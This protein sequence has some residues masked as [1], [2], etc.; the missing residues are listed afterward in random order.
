MWAYI[1][2]FLMRRYRF[3]HIERSLIKTLI[4]ILAIDAFRTLFESIFFGA[5]STSLSGFLPIGVHDFLIR[6]EI[7]F[8]PKFLNVI[9]AALIIGILL[10]KWFPAEKRDRE[11]LESTIKEH[12]NKLEKRN[13]QLR[14]EITERKK[15][16]DTL[17]KSEEQYRLLFDLLPFGGEVIDSKGKIIKCSPSTSQML[18]YKTSEIIGKHITELLT[19]DSVHIFKKKFPVLLS[20]ESVTADIKMIRKDG[21]KLNIMRAAQPILNSDGKVES[22]LALNIDITERKK[23]EEQIAK[24]LEIK[25]AL[26][27]EVYHR[28]KNNMQVIIS[29]L[30]VQSRNLENRS[31]TEN[32]GINFL[33][34]SL[35]EMINKIKSMSLVHE[36]LYQ[37]KDLSH[38]NL[39]EYIEDL[40]RH[41]MI[42]FGIRS[43]NVILKLELEEIFVLIDS[44]IPLSMILN[45]MISNVFKYAFPHTKHDELF[46]KLYRGENETINIHLSDNG[47]GIPKN[48]DL[49]NVNSMGLK[50]VFDLTKYQLMGEVKYV[51]ENGLKWDLS[52]KDDQHRARV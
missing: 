46:V 23:A 3:G 10:Y 8:I 11:L 29:L 5:R 48:I 21:S 24:D 41:L 36:K 35:S 30:K 44:A 39:K 4:L 51:I 28:T 40:V 1:L 15:A 22:V 52:F 33:H 25:T 16:E 45:E 14:Y 12:I 17:K 6:S 27:Q 47:V 42:S 13:K 7:V 43:E 34:D 20:G 38:I 32:E 50:T 18:G 2:F 19:P 26:L 31:L 37:A 49:E 9:V